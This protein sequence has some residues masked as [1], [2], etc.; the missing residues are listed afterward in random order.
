MGDVKEVKATVRSVH[1]FSSPRGACQSRKNGAN[2]IGE[3]GVIFVR[4]VQYN[5]T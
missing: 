1:Y 5:V 2:Q 4:S 3:T